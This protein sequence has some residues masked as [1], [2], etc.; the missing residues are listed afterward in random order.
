MAFGVSKK[1]WP[2]LYSLQG[3]EFLLHIYPDKNIDL[4]HVELASGYVERKVTKIMARRE[5]ERV[6]DFV[7]NFEKDR[8]LFSKWGYKRF[9]CI[10]E[11][12]LKALA[13]RQFRIGTEFEVRDLETG[14]VWD[15]V[16]DGV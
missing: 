14:R 9:G 5:L 8:G 11:Q 7:Q 12:L 4:G 3:S 13:W 15:G 6:E 1:K 2:F 10:V 16:W